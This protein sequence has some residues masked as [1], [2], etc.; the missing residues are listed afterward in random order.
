M[1]EVSSFILAAQG[2]LIDKQMSDDIRSEKRCK[3]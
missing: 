2:A 3:Q 1:M